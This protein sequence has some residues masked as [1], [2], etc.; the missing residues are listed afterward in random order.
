MTFKQKDALEKK[1]AAFVEGLEGYYR[2]HVSDEFLTCLLLRD[3]MCGVG[4]P[5]KEAYH[6]GCLVFE[7]KLEYGCRAGG[8]GHHMGQA[9]AAAMEHE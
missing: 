4:T 7:R 2:T 5:R 6:V 3:M 9:F 8:N 1:V